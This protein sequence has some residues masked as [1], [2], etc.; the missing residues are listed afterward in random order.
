[1][2]I[3]IYQDILKDLKLKITDIYV[4]EKNS[5]HYCRLGIIN[6]THAF[7][8]LPYDKCGSSKTV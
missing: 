5:V 7:F 4:N 6:G 8:K 2:E 3:I 1:M